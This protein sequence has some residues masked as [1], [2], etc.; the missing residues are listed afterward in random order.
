MGGVE[1]PLPWLP[2]WHTHRN[3]FTDTR[4]HWNTE[5]DS[6]LNSCFYTLIVEFSGHLLFLD[7]ND[8]VF[9]TLNWWIGCCI[10]LRVCTVRTP[11]AFSAAQFEAVWWCRDVASD[12][13]VSVT[14]RYKMPHFLFFPPIL[15]CTEARA[16]LL[17]D[18]LEYCPRRD[19]SLQH[20]HMLVFFWGGGC[21]FDALVYLYM[22]WMQ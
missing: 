10:V 14:K 18:F 15:D 3:K 22:S 12:P 19:K 21:H 8:R 9:S 7:T 16:F 6:C 11:V 4:L 13:L 1:P 2:A 20:F 17:C 5:L